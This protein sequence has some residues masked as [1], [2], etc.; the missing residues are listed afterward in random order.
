MTTTA[1]DP[2]FATAA[3]TREHAARTAPPLPAVRPRRRPAL[4]ALGIALTATGVLAT[5]WLVSHASERV[6]VLSVSRTVAYGEVI[7]IAD[8]AFANVTVDPT[9]PT[10]SADRLDEV[11][12][13]L[14]AQQL[15][16]GSL[17]G[18]DSLVVAVAPGQGQVLVPVAI[19][20]TRMPVALL[21]PGDILLVV[22][23]P[24]ADGDH[25]TT[26]PST[27]KATVIRLAEPDLNGVTVVDLAVATADGPAL[28]ARAATGRIAIVLLPKGS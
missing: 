15:I 18:P 10:I 21:S 1:P 8:V 17:L 12:G 16:S 25:S 20:S 9:V 26:A 13:K 6:S 23:I 22:D 11:L 4:L 14:A 3:S 2:K 27:V 5:V 7:T 28:A 19:A 24:A